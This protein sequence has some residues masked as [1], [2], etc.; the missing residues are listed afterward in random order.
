MIATDWSIALGQW[1]L[2]PFLII[3]LVVQCWRTDEL[4]TLA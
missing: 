2:A 1:P 4:E 3:Q